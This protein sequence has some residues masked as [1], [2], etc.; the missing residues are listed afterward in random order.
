MNW[1]DITIDSAEAD[2][3][4]LLNTWWSW[5]LASSYKPIQ[6]SFFGDWFLVNDDG[7][8]LFLDVLEGSVEKISDSQ[9][10]LD[11]MLNEE[12]W[13][14]RLLLTGFVIAMQRRGA[15]RA[16]GMCYGYRVHP[17]IGG[18]TEVSNLVL[19]D[20]ETWQAIC[21]Q[22][23]QQVKQMKPGTR[24]RRLEHEGGLSLRL[25]PDDSD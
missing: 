5:L 15:H 14:D 19:L 16:T 4:T 24:I 20:I 13:Q 7:Q 8:I 22:I 3:P 1:T 21:G 25:I 17:I 10:Q 6:L 9:E 2:F 23:H 11:A 18:K 12:D